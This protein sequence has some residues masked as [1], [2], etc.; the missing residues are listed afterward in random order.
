MTSGTLQGIHFAVKHRT[1]LLDPAV[2]TAADD[3]IG[4]H[5]NRADGNAS[6][7]ET[8]PGL[9]DGRIEEGAHP[10]DCASSDGRIWQY[11]A[12]FASH[13]SVLSTG[14]SR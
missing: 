7:G 4:M 13:V 5:E 6:F 11:A 1:A 2:V 14:G 9:G 3:S 8:E 10:G 12:C